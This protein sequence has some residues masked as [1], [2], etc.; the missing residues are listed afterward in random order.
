MDDDNIFDENDAL[1]YIIYEEMTNDNIKQ[2]GP[3]MLKA[4]T[5]ICR[6]EC[7]FLQLISEYHNLE[8]IL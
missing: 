8:S 3:I 1:D 2:A 7:G 5:E 6:I 4:E